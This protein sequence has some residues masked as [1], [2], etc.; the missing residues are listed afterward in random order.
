ML[1][2]DDPAVL[3]RRVAAAARP[4]LIGL[5]VDGVLAPLVDHAD[6][7]RLVDG[8]ADSI[9]A[10]AGHDHVQIA[11]VSGRAVDDL[12]RFEFDSRVVLVGSHGL[13]SYGQPMKPLD[14]VENDRLAALIVL[15]DRAAHQAGDGA[16]VETK[17]AS[18][19]VHIR[20]A[21]PETG[22]KALDW[23]APLAGSVKGANVKAGSDVLELFTRSADKGR[24]IYG[25]AA[26]FDASAT[27]FVGDDI[28]DE[29]AFAALSST[30]ISV[31]VGDAPTIAQHRLRD[32]YAVAIWL[33][34]LVAENET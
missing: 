17:P 30:D 5:D 3:A 21:D 4:L 2:Y 10:L 22:A 16:W 14:E 29:D 11:I 15:A 20:Q 1:T 12:L 13:E 28:T 32:P 7:A 25:L 24:A 27:A 26:E 18:V 19:T 34:K 31:K 23:L 6:D 33:R 9:G 8:V